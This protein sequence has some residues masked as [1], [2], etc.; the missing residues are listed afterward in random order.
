MTRRPPTCSKCRREHFNFVKCE[1]L[2]DYQ[3]QIAKP[4]PHVVRQP[5]EDGLKDWGDRY[6][7]VER[8]GEN[9][10]VLPREPLPTGRVTGLDEP[11]PRLPK[12]KPT[13]VYPEPPPA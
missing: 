6:R 4:R 9:V 5:R 12:P 2:A 7:V 1:E 8:T 3:K 13:L 11:R 10:F